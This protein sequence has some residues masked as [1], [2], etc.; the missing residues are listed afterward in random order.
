MPPFLA[1][2]IV[3]MLMFPLLWRESRVRPGVSAASWIPT[4]WLLINGSR[5]VGQWLNLT[6]PVHAADA[7]VDGSPVD[8][9]VFLFLMLSS[10]AVLVYRRFALGRLVM[11]NKVWVLFF[12]YCGLSVAWSDFP[13]VTF[14]RWFKAAGDP[15][16]VLVLLTEARP[17][18]AIEVVLRRC[19]YVLLPL[20]VLFIKYYPHLGRNFSPWG[21]QFFTGVTTN[22]NL[23]GYTLFVL[24]SFFVAWL[25]TRQAAEPADRAERRV[26]RDDMIITLV[27]LLIIAYLFKM[28]DS[29]TAVVALAAATS[30]A[31][32]LRFEIIQRHFGKFAMVGLTFSMLLQMTLNINEAVIEGVG[33]DTTLTGRTEIWSTALGLV[34]NPVLGAGFETFWLG[35]RL[36]AMWA[37]FPVFLPNQAHNGYIEM[38]L[39][40]GAVGLVLFLCALASSYRSIHGRLLDAGKAATV[41][42]YEMRLGVLGIAFFVGYLLYNITEA[43][44]KP[45]TLLFVT[46]LAL[47]IRY[48]P[49]TET[50][51]VPA[52]P[53]PAAAPP[54]PVAATPR[55]SQWRATPRPHSG[56]TRD[57][58][59]AAGPGQRRAGG[60]KTGRIGRYVVDRNE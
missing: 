35:N 30:V 60:V 10:M 38:Y 49:R 28:A 36:L 9:M 44:F 42:I 16:M 2:V 31:F 17:A 26:R 22:K 11:Q 23:L 18:V 19:A 1:L 34:S 27:F 56:P 32:A 29:Q 50:A 53:R 5:S 54:V 51:T 3:L 43:T 41:D 46:F 8:R 59:S 57:G 4:V 13:S 55:V 25:F 37:A 45:L 24:G 12:V 48:A 52:R 47:A 6:A 33:R 58:R 39:N 20:S 21:A 7:Y 40:L 14:R 15:L